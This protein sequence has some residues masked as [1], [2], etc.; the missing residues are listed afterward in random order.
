M[1]AT[2]NEIDGLNIG[3]YPTIKWYGAD[4][5]HPIDFEGERDYDDMKDFIEEKINPDYVKP[6]REKKA[7]P[8]HDEDTEDEDHSG[9]DHSGHG[10]HDHDHDHDHDEP[11]EEELEEEKPKIEL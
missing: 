9:H 5:S 6:K 2:A 1:D 3:G 7:A 11:I 10:H 8:K 4:K